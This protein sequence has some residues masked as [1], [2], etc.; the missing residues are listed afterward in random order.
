MNFKE[1]LITVCLALVVTRAVEYFFFTSEKKRSEETMLSGE[2][3]VMQRGC[4]DIRPFNTEVDFIDRD[5]VPQAV[6]TEVITDHARLVF[7]THGASLEQLDFLRARHGMQGDIITT[8]FPASTPDKERRCFLV[9]FDEA[10]PYYYE[11]FSRVDQDDRTVLSYKANYQGGVIEKVFTIF[12]SLHRIDMT[13]RLLS[14]KKNEQEGHL[15]IFLPAPVMLDI[16]AYDVTSGVMNDTQGSVVTSLRDSVENKGWIKPS[17]FGTENRY[18]VHTMI[19][20]PHFFAHRGY[21]SLYGTRGLCAIIESDQ[22][23]DQ[24]AAWTL[25]FYC[26]PKEQAAMTPVDSRL[27]RGLGISG[28]LAPISQWLLKLL[29]Y[30]YNYFG[31]YGIAII[32]LT[33]LMKI[34]LLPFSYKSTEGMQ[35]SAEVNRKLKYLQQKYKDDP[36]RLARER[37]ELIQR[38]GMPG[39]AGCLPLLMQIPIFIA[40]S[41]VLSTSIELYRAPFAIWSNLASPD[42][43]YI[44][45]IL[46]VVAMLVQSMTIDPKQRTAM[47]I[48]AFLFGAFSVS[49]S[50]GLCLYIAVSAILGVVQSTIQ[51]RWQAA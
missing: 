25:S 21:Y 20:D 14:N 41:R 19:N 40:L 11:L 17:V 46:I 33:I 7:S 8:I 35:K 29:N 26:G 2:S 15:R 28:I 18:F 47:L 30:L 16:A 43:Y 36:E 12:K 51:K 37:I 34:I 31:N 32:M 39:L 5:T 10:T 4:R 44:L 45:P 3:F 42:P 27:A 50:A 6:K 22:Q 9:G 48:P 23:R 24:E 13:I 38:E 49:F 1:V